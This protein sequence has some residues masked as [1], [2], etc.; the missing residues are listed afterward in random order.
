[1]N[2]PQ[3]S[4]K[5]SSFS[6]GTLLGLALLTAC[7]GQPAPGVAP[8]APAPAPVEVPA[9]APTAPQPAAPQPAQPQ[10]TQ[11]Q[12]TQPQPAQPQPTQ[13]VTPISSISGLSIAP[14]QASVAAGGSL[15]LQATLQGS[16][17]YDPRLN[18]KST[19]GQLT[20]NADGSATLNVPSTAPAGQIMVTATSVADASQSVSSV[21]T[22]L[23]AP[24]TVSL[25]QSAL[26]ITEGGSASVGYSGAVKSVSLSSPS[27]LVS[28]VSAQSG[29]LTLQAGSPGSGEVG[30]RFEMQDGGTQW[31]TL[32]VTVNAAP[33]PQPAPAP[34][35]GG[36]Q[37][38]SG[39]DRTPSAEEL[40]V[41]RLTNEV[42]ARGANCGGVNYP[43]VPALTWND[44]LAHAA[45][46]HAEDMGQRRYFS[47]TTPDG[48]SFSNRISAAGY[49]WITA[50]ENIAAGYPTPQK[51]VD[52]WVT[53]PGHCANLMNSTLKELGVGVVSVPGSPYNLYWTQDFGTG[54]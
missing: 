31:A 50:A 14:V 5:R 48:F 53:S 35:P 22:V 54:Y 38:Y 3:P 12:P 13:P 15:R 18:W 28:S 29:T 4:P 43:P 40:D 2:R 25:N 46:N 26:S 7:G 8:K 30:L 23:A 11:P 1:M 45:R 10:P 24:Q 37:W 34:T 33:A 52:G 20:Q 21:I 36:Y 47:H 39:T 27:A 44:K 6:L 41:L 51:V 49:R 17:N 9:P 16:G 19:G 32:Q 42:R